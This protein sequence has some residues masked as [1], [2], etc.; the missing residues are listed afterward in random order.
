MEL[1]DGKGEQENG[2]SKRNYGMVF[3]HIFYHTF[4]TV[5]RNEHR[6]D[7][8]DFGHGSSPVSLK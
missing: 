5:Y 3:V 7:G 8:P 2:K 1:R 6:R 4:N